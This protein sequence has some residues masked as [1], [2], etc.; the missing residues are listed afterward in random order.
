MSRASTIDR[1]ERLEFITARVKSDEPT[2]IADIAAE[3]GV[4]IR[5]VSR[6]VD[7]LRTQG[8]PIDTDRGRGGGIRLHR[9]WGVGRLNLTYSEAIDLLVGLAV[10]ERTGG[11]LFLANLD[12]VRRKLLASFSADMNVRIKDLKARILISDSASPAVLATFRRPRTAIVDVL[13]Q[14]FVLRHRLRFTYRT[15]D[16]TRTE[17][18]VEPHY[19]LLSPPVWYV[20]GWDHLRDDLRTFRCDRITGITM[21][22]ERFAVQPK[23]DFAPALEGVEAVAP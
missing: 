6:D 13:H 7:L 9:S 23:D 5:T 3:L 16:G 8:V 12:S 11:P 20:L 19:L 2:T 21:L 22:D 1:L 10:A 4:S 18:V 15:G 14:A 17:R